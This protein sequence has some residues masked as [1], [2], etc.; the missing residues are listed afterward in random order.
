MKVNGATE[1]DVRPIGRIRVWDASGFLILQ[2]RIESCDRL[3]DAEHAAVAAARN[4]WP[5]DPR[6]VTVEIG[7]N[8]TVHVVDG[9]F[10]RNPMEF[11]SAMTW[12]TNS[13]L[14]ANESR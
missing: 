6:H 14:D 5:G 11:V 3:P 2:R 1:I 12:P 10:L 8:H 7:D 9:P 4:L 13:L